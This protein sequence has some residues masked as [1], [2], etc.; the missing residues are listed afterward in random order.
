MYGSLTTHSDVALSGKSADPVFIPTPTDAAIERYPWIDIASEPTRPIE[1]A[2]TAVEP[3]LSPLPHLQGQA[4]R[5]S[6][7]PSRTTPRCPPVPSTSQPLDDSQTSLVGHLSTLGRLNPPPRWSRL[8]R[9]THATP[10]RSSRE[11]PHDLVPPLTPPC[12]GWQSS[13]WRLAVHDTSS[14]SL[15]LSRCSSSF[16]GLA[17]V[18][19]PALCCSSS[20]CLR[21][22][23][24][25]SAPTS[26]DIP[27]PWR[28]VY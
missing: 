23:A 18:L 19:L 5:P 11:P 10:I 12:H 26:W 28:R 24:R 7:A 16:Y 1:R 14:V 22:C 4:L 20:R 21:L 13:S 25:S 9:E 6:W 3:C 2:A 8:Q 17:V 15:R 27:P